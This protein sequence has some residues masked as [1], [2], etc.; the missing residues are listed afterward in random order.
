VP[1]SGG[2]TPSPKAKIAAVADET[3]ANLTKIDHVVVLMLK[4][5]SGISPGS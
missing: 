4:N 1:V 5:R 2:R 3:P